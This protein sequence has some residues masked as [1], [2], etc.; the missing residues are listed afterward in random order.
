MDK[1][2]KTIKIEMKEGAVTMV[3]TDKDELLF[4][5]Y[6]TARLFGFRD[7]HECVR[8]YA[9]D[10][11]LVVLETPGGHQPVKC[12]PIWDVAAIAEKSR[13]PEAEVISLKI[14]TV[15]RN[16]QIDELQERNLALRDALQDALD[17][18]KGLKSQLDT[19]LTSLLE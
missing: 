2:I 6:E 4:R 8:S 12:I 9:T 1:A 15:M 19:I 11:A 7:D 13:R 17:G 5:A 18:L 3:K 14:L 16:M 10:P